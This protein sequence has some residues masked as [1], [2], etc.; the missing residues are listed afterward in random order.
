[1]AYDIE[2]AREQ[3]LEFLDDES[4]ERYARETGTN[5]TN[6]RKV[7]RALRGAVSSTLDDYVRRGGDRFDEELTLTTD[8]DTG[9][10]EVGGDK[11]AHVRSIRVVSGSSS[12]RV[13]EGDKHVGGRADL[14]ERSLIATVVRL[15]EVPPEPD[16]DDLL[17]GTVEGAARSWDAFD[18][19]V[20]ARAAKTLGIKDL[21]PE[22]Q[23]ILREQIA[24]RE[25]SVLSHSRT[26]AAKPWPERRPSTTVVGAD[27][28]WLFFPHEQEL[29]LVFGAL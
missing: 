15:F 17:M 26:P 20:C 8:A 9:K 3:V 6:Y 10:V 22:R 19:L 12:Y 11:L 21:K 24:E 25:K 4:G 16:V 23:A 14:V 28:R 7:D 29:A 1:M 5:T 18:E 13:M 27:L 2:D